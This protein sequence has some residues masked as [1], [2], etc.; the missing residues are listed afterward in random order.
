MK[1]DSQRRLA[2]EILGVG[3]H[4]I[5]MDPERLEDI[6]M[7]ITR[8]EIKKLIHEGAIRVKP[9]KGISRGRKR[10]AKK[11][12]RK[13]RRSGPGSRKG[14]KGEVEWKDKIRAIRRELR[15]LRDRGIIDRSTYRKLYLMA[16]GGAFK[17]RSD[18]LRYVKEQVLR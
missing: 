12:K 13:G 9:E 17:S 18:L 10:K 15:R 5:W 14:P 11:Q 3:I 4:R 8:E 6:E 7:A 1:L 16:K 2:A